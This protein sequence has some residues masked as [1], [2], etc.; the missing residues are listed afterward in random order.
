M[1][2]NNE[3]YVSGH[4]EHHQPWLSLLSLSGASH[5][6]QEPTS[7][8]GPSSPSPVRTAWTV[9]GSPQ[10]C[11]AQTWAVLSQACP[12]AYILGQPWPSLVPKEVCDGQAWSCPSAPGC[13]APAGGWW[14]GHWCQPLT[15]WRC[16][17]SQLPV[18]YTR[19]K[20]QHKTLEPNK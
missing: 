19:R 20:L 16:R 4:S 10:S 6:A 12:W 9:S 11:P 7:S 1:W 17:P 2:S 8:P 14:D 18:I 13:P 3:I 15:L 5:I